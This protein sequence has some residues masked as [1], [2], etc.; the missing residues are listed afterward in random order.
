MF[1]DLELKTVSVEFN[2]R[3]RRKYKEK[4]NRKSIKLTS[5]LW[6]GSTFANVGSL[7][8]KNFCVI[9]QLETVHLHCSLKSEMS[10]IEYWKFNF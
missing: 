1:K 2:Y 6:V 9:F 10:M 4:R 8:F 7:S 3:P 5:E